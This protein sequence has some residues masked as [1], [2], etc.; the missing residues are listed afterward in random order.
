[1][2]E[3]A[4]GAPDLISANGCLRLKA[5]KLF[6]L[7]IHHTLTTMTDSVTTSN[8]EVALLSAGN[9]PVFDVQSLG[10]ALDL[11]LDPND[12]CKDASKNAANTTLYSPM[13]KSNTSGQ[14]CHTDNS[15]KRLDALKIAQHGLI[16]QLSYPYDVCHIIPCATGPG[17]VSTM[18]IDQLNSFYIVL[19]HLTRLHLCH[20]HVVW[21]QDFQSKLAGTY[22]IVSHLN[23]FATLS[24]T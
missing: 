21:K 18:S 6:F 11:I 1:M 17:I 15:K 23:F 2:A 3:W 22:Y 8:Q 19:F 4:D 9:P 12:E 24:S 10:N 5:V 13:P 7:Q 16:T 20:K 14:S